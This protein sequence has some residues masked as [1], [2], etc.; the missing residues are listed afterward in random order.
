MSVI[1]LIL[2]ANTKAELVAWAKANP[3][4]APLLDANNKPVKGVR[5]CWWAGDGKLMTSLGPPATYLNGFIG[6]LRLHTTYFDADKIDAQGEQWARS[7]VVKH[8]KDNGTPGT[9]AGGAISYYEL[10][11]VRIFRP[12]D[13]QAWLTANNLPGHEWVGGNSY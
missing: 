12:A 13:V 5:Y 8:I 1:D 7:N 11:G 3:P 2:W 9:V 4:S 10:G 6:L